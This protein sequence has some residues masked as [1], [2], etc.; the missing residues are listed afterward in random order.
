[1]YTV[2]ALL[3]L[4]LL[5]WA[6]AVRKRSGFRPAVAQKVCMIGSASGTHSGW[7]S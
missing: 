2:I 3:G 5:T 4:M 1:M 7:W 6:A